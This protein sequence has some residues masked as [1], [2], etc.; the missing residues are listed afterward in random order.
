MNGLYHYDIYYQLISFLEGVV[1]GWVGGW[2]GSHGISLSQASPFV[3]G[4][5]SCDSGWKFQQQHLKENSKTYADTRECYSTE[6]MYEINCVYEYWDD[7]GDVSV[8][9]SI[10]KVC[11]VE[12][13]D[14]DW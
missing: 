11:I 1:G 5:P 8:H 12:Q 4:S 9:F 14:E 10:C 3:G 6:D 7:D 2:G 13:R